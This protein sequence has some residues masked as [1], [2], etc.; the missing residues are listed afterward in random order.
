MNFSC[1]L[2]LL[3]GNFSSQTSLEQPKLWDRGR[4]GWV[5]TTPPPPPPPPHNLV[6]SPQSPIIPPEQNGSREHF[7]LHQMRPPAT[8]RPVISSRTTLNLILQELSE[9]CSVPF[10]ILLLLLPQEFRSP[11]VRAPTGCS[12]GSVFST[13]LCSWAT[14]SGSLRRSRPS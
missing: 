12:S 6:T 5:K 3:L 4:G 11:E 13:I 7:S 10:I 8:C 1:E 2:F 14:S 9:N